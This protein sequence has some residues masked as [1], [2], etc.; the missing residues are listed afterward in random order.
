MREA[1]NVCLRFGEVVHLRRTYSN[2]LRFVHRITHW[3]IE[4]PRGLEPLTRPWPTVHSPFQE[5]SLMDNG[6]SGPTGK[7]SEQFRSFS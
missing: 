3:L 5:Q 4:V 6:A 1:S 7:G 2:L